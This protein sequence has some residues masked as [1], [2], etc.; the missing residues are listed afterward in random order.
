MATI[1]RFCGL[2]VEWE[3]VGTKREPKWQCFNP[4][5]T[6]HWDRCSQASFERVKRE[7]EFFTGTDKTIDS[8]VTGYRAPYKTQLVS[9]TPRK[10]AVGKRWREDGCD[11]G[12]PP[13]ELC[14]PDCKHKTA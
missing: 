13:W 11:C 8:T 5:D 9:I 10:P 2:P 4:D 12:R 7:G 14:S 3:N 1:C 6:I